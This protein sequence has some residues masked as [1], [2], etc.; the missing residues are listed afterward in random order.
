MV[1][2]HLDLRPV[3]YG[4]TPKHLPWSDTRSPRH[5]YLDLTPVLYST[6]PT[7]TWHQSPMSHL[8]WSNTSPLWYNIYLDL[9]N[10]VHRRET[11]TLTW[12]QSPM[13]HLPWS[14]TSSLRYI[15]YFDLKPVLHSRPTTLTWHQSFTEYNLPWPDTTPPQNMLTLTWQQS[16]TEYSYLDLTP[17]LH[18]ICLPWSDTNH[19]QN[20][21]YLD[22]DLW[23][24]ST[25]YA[26]FDLTPI[27]HRI[28]PTLTWHQSSTEYNLPWPDTSPPPHTHTSSIRAGKRRQVTFIV[29]GFLFSCMISLPGGDNSNC[30]CRQ[31]LLLR[32]NTGGIVHFSSLLPDNRAWTLKLYFTERV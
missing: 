32:T 12:H 27:I 10:P 7:S 22:L 17:V 26:F 28:G 25:E 4:T 21:A 24:T 14:N 16:S 8:P 13:S 5:I 30:D 23:R 29:D 18:S 2:A 3:R 19:P 9:K 1:H 11:R 31:K 15:I 20:R 6:V